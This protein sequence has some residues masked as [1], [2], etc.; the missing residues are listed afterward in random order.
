MDLDSF[1]S[2]KWTRRQKRAECTDSASLHIHADQRVDSSLLH[3]D[4]AT[5]RAVQSTLAV[6]A[7]DTG[8]P[9]SWLRDT[10]DALDLRRTIA[11]PDKDRVC[12][13]YSG[14]IRGYNTHLRFYT[15]FCGPCE[16]FRQEALAAK[17]ALRGIEEGADIKWPS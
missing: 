2:A 4:P 12:G 16:A 10:L 14:T 8:D 15:R 9:V 1:T 11:V 17:T 13:V 7:L 6:L 3:D 5:Q